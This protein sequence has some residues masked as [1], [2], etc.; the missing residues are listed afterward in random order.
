VTAS[1]TKHRIDTITSAEYREL[2]VVTNT[3]S[4]VV[5]NG[6]IVSLTGD[7]TW[8]VTG[9]S[10]LSSLTV[11]AGST[12]AGSNGETPTVTVDG[13]V[14]PLVAGT[15]YTGNVVVTLG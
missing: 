1:T 7:S 8:T 9:T 14:T 10:Y 11:E 5:N 3:A 13:V 15:T 12:L 4:D 6:V 2:G